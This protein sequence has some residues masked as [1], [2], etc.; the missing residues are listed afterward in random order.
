MVISGKNERQEFRINSAGTCLSAKRPGLLCVC[1][2][3]AVFARTSSQPDCFLL[4]GRGARRDFAPDDFYAP[5]TWEIITRKHY[6]SRVVSG[7]SSQP[8]RNVCHLR[9]RAKRRFWPP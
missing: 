1:V 8:R 6:V 3:S 4:R 9:T 2:V 7:T 5:A